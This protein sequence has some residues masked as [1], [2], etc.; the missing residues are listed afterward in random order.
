MSITPDD[1]SCS[2]R[3]ILDVVCDV[4]DFVHQDFIRAVRDVQEH[5]VCSGDVAVVEQGAFQS[6]GNGRHGPAF[7]TG[8]ARAHDGGTRFTH[9]RLD[10]VHVDVDVTGQGDDFCNP[11][12]SR[13]QHFVSI[14]EGLLQ[15]EVAEEF[16]EFVVADDQQ[17]IH[18]RAHRFQSFACLSGPAFSFEVEWNG[19]NSNRQNAEVFTSLC[20]DRCCSSAG[21]SA[22]SSSDKHHG[23]VV[24]QF[25][26]HVIEVFD[27]GIFSNFRT[28]PC[29]LARSQGGAELD[30]HRNIGGL[31]SLVVG[32]AYNEVDTLDAL[33][34]H[35]I[36]GIRAAATYTDDFD[37][38]TRGNGECKF[39]LMFPNWIGLLLRICGL[40]TPAQ[41]L[42]KKNEEC[43]GLML[44]LAF[45]SR[46]LRG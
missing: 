42:D 31:Q 1:F 13:A 22:H 9:D 5:K 27:G 12:S 16:A 2:S 46:S 24:F 8:T 37:G 40:L 45:R 6:F 3:L 44:V 15:G 18:G 34:V 11:F 23:G 17:C 26:E 25:V 33:F 39:H 43:L 14:G 36:D 29:S 28:A 41:E 20:N 7:A 30:A 32:I 21:S 35:V 19:Y 38:R 10:I 4:G